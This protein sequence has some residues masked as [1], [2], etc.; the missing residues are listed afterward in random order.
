MLVI[1]GS[2]DIRPDWP[3]RQIAELVPHGRFESI[4]GAGHVPWLT[5]ER[6]L[7]AMVRAFA[8]EV[9]HAR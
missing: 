2:E 9:V 3:A 1:A 4:A 8:A 6:E 7:R 5:H